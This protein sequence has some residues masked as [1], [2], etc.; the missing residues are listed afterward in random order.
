MFAYSG[1]EIIGS[2]ETFA[3]RTINKHGLDPNLT[4]VVRFFKDFG[5][6]QLAKQMSDFRAKLLVES[7]FRT[8]ARCHLID[9]LDYV[10][11]VY[12]LRDS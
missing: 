12:D 2:D 1:Q 3:K 4:V 7:D 6:E 5:G 10:I 8:A 9:R 11:A